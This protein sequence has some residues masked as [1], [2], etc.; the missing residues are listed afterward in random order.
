MTF[1]I[2]PFY[3]E[4]KIVLHRL[5]LELPPSNIAPPSHDDATSEISGNVLSFAI[6]TFCATVKFK[7]LVCDQK[8]M[9]K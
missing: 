5:I 2:C 9:F 7:L 1:L 8:Q 6:F 4:K 3:L